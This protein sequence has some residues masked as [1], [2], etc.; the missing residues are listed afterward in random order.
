M[1]YTM[2]INNLILGETY[3]YTGLCE[4]LGEKTKAGDSKVAQ[5]K[6]W[7]C[8]FK[9]EHPINL[10]TKK[11]SKKFKIVEI[12]D[13][14][15]EKVDG[16][17]NGNSTIF[18]N[19]ELSKAIIEAVMSDYAI[20]SVFTSDSK[21]I[22]TN[23]NACSYWNINQLAEKVGL[24]SEYYRL[25]KE[26]PEQLEIM[27]LTKASSSIISDYNLIKN[28]ILGGCKILKEEDSIIDY[29]YDIYICYSISRTQIEDEEQVILHYRNPS[30]EELKIINQCEQDTVEYFNAH[31]DEFEYKGKDLDAYNKI[32]KQI[33]QHIRQK[34]WDYCF[35]LCKQQIRNYKSHARKLCIEYDISII[36]Q[37]SDNIQEDVE[38]T[39]NK[40]YAIKRVE[41]ARKKGEKTIKDME[42]IL[43][44]KSKKSWGNVK[45]I[46]EAEVQSKYGMTLDE[47][48][49]Q[50]DKAVKARQIAYITKRL[51]KELSEEDQSALQV[52]IDGLMYKEDIL[53][54]I[55][56]IPQMLDMLGYESNSFIKGY[57]SKKVDQIMR[58]LAWF[59]E[60]DKQVTESNCID[61]GHF[62][63]KDLVKELKLANKV[64]IYTDYQ[65]NGEEGWIDTY[66][67]INECHYIKLIANTANDIYFLFLS[68]ANTHKLKKD[69]MRVG[70]LTK[71]VRERLEQIK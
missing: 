63:Q 42:D 36:A 58:E 64:E 4:A 57:T 30:E 61:V 17:S 37:L 52:Y 71:K 65:W 44:S 20:Q 14:P 31:K 5:L 67:I 39:V 28:Q 51:L 12:Y 3:D 70:I 54:I 38:D 9:W 32:H 13:T 19:G 35:D 22:V 21:D 34:V 69:N 62:K 59:D 60:F 26:Y 25:F 53:S 2:Q 45:K 46:R 8:F 16:R 18:K 68:I 23:V 40:I 6:Q 48:K 33:P 24:V 56:Q 11:T 49:E 29:H 27:G 10:K 47:A 55:N 50:I 1:I 66:L 43:N 7:A 15:L 41:D